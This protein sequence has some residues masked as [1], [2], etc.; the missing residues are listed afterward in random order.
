M[1]SFVPDYVD[2]VDDQDNLNVLLM[3]KNGSNVD[4]LIFAH[5]DFT[6]GKVVLISIPRDLYYKERK[7]NSIYAEKGI[8]AQVAAVEDVVGYKIRHY[9]LVDMY[10]FRDIVDDLGGVDVTLKE[11]L[12]DP[13]Y[14]VCDG[15]VCSTL[16]YT[17]GFH[18]LSGMEAL[19]VARSRHTTSDYSRAERQQLILQGIQSKL[20]TLGLGDTGTLFDVFTTALGALETDVSLSQ[21][22]QYYLKYQGY[23]IDGGNVIS[24]ANVLQAVPVPVNYVTSHPIQV[25]DDGNEPETCKNGYAI[26]TLQPQ[27][28]N[29]NLIRW[30]VE[31]VVEGQ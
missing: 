20:R 22:M 13:T 6:D 27:N 7:I 30:W 26:D 15:D 17:A 28:Q 16:Y 14:K 11:D 4:T 1:P 10:V 25:C 24:S 23:E 18:H 2:L 21:A 5:V 12:I 29:W 3:G 19:R 8:L 31:E 9:A